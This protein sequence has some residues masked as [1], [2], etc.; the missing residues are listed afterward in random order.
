MGTWIITILLQ[1]TKKR[2]TLQSL[3]CAAEQNKIQHNK[4]TQKVSNQHKMEEE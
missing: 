1:I 3:T 2:N 4:N